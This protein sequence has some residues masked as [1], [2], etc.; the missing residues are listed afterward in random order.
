MRFNLVMGNQAADAD[1]IISS[2]CLSY[3]MNHERG[4]MICNGDSA[5]GSKDVI[6]MPII[7]ISRS[8][9]DLRPETLLLFKRVGVI[10]R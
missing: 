2:I 4:S 9:M 3:L 1:S 8:E 10:A 7:P 6:A 5:D